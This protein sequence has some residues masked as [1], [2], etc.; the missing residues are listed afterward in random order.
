MN[1]IQ[2]NIE[3]VVKIH[4]SPFFKSLG[5]RNSGRTFSFQWED[6][7]RIVNIQSWKYNDQNS[8][9]FTINLGVY[10][11]KVQNSTNLI[12]KTFPPREY[13]CQIRERIGALIGAPH[14]D[15]WWDVMPSSDVSE[16]SKTI[17]GHLRENAI[18][19]LNT[20]SIPEEA[21]AYYLGMNMK[22]MAALLYWAAGNS[23]KASEL[24][25]ELLKTSDNEKLKQY[26]SEWARKNR[27]K[28]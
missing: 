16:L 11:A 14:G 3:N 25:E 1:I 18:P 15:I 22:G 13:E 20:M 12:A 27:V 7:Y 9:K 26:W 17:I 23:K 8:G 5:Y 19:W 24:I 10:L 4:L 21:A 2:K 28:N 6:N